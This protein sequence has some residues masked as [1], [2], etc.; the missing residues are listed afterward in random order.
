MDGD[1][2]ESVSNFQRPGRPTRHHRS[3]KNVV[4]TVP[5]VSGR[6]SDGSA[7][8]F[9]FH[10]GAEGQGEQRIVSRSSQA[11]QKPV[12]SLDL[13]D[14]RFT[15]RGDRDSGK[16]LRRLPILHVTADELGGC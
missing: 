3:V 15:L 2:P 4:Q 1:R 16:E 6:E 13:L 10:R 11:W 5:P 14:Q 9:E 7:S 8:F 12:G